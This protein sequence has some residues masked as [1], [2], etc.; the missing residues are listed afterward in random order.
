ML[1]Y[2][3]AVAFPGVLAL[4]IKR[5]L[6]S[7]E[8]GGYDLVAAASGLS[9]GAELGLG[10][11]AGFY[12]LDAVLV[13][14][15]VP[16]AWLLFTSRVPRA[17]RAWITVAFA[18]V[19]SFVYFV[20][21]KCLWEV[22]TFLPARVLAAGAFG[23]GRKYAA[24]YMG[25]S[26]MAKFLVLLASVVGAAAAGWWFDRARGGRRAAPTWRQL[27]LV[28]VPCLAA[29]LP[30][31]RSPFHESA[32]LRALTTF[33]EPG[34]AMASDDMPQAT[35]D[36][37]A[38]YRRLSRAPIPNEPSALFGRAR[39]YNVL[40]YLYE[41]LPDTCYQLSRGASRDAFRH[42]RSLEGSAI[43]AGHHYATYPYSRRAYFS[44]YS[45][46]YPPHGIRDFTE[47]VWAK[48]AAL[49]APGMARSLRDAGYRTAA[50]VPEEPSAWEDDV[51]RYAALGFDHHV[52]P[53]NAGL[54]TSQLQGQP[55]ARVAWQRPQDDSSRHQLLDAITA[56]A[57]DGKP[58]LF[59]F[60]PQLTHGPWPGAGDTKS[61]EEVC[62]RGAPLFSEV[63]AGLGEVLR[64]LDETGQRERTIVV[65]AGDHGLRTRDEFPGFQGATLAEVT[66]RVPMLIAV[67]GLER[68]TRV[69]WVT[70]HVDISPSVLDLLG[71]SRGREMEQGSPVWSPRLADRRV[72]VLAQGYLGVDGYVGRG[73]AAMLN[74]FLSS[75]ALANRGTLEFQTRD[76]LRTTVE[77][78]GAVA[79]VVESFATAQAAWLRRLAAPAAP[80]EPG[81]AAMLRNESRAGEV[82]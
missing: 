20:E 7:G 34:G 12:L 53:P 28:S 69:P 2:A 82:R 49:V 60:H 81:A 76:L 31:P 1:F 72:F 74:Y 45:G 29:F 21:L 19:L 26:S 38:G 10:Q 73:R 66:F 35:A 70:S 30:A 77:T 65:V 57:R 51:R 42:L 32:A 54:K 79:D 44:I 25:S 22:G 67:P 40:V 14:V 55:D 62:A 78:N 9:G 33:A 64:A 48:G 58:W 61:V 39:G 80:G 5:K 37:L 3:A 11:R 43:V 27:A 8:G 6:V 46:W 18:A 15:L 50:F 16:A 63:D 13:L 68:P 52:V 24:E 71:V 47:E 41:T 56:G 75:A 4:V 59:A 36:L 17:L 23:A